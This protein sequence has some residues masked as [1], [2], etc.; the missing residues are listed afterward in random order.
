[1]LVDCSCS[2][3]A[4]AINAAVAMASTATMIG[5]MGRTGHRPGLA[6]RSP[7]IAKI[8]RPTPP[9]VLEQREHRVI[10]PAAIAPLRVSRDAFEVETEPP[11]HAQRR[12]IAGGRRDAH[13]M[14]AE[15]TET[16]VHAEGGCFGHVS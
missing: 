8:L 13:A 3:A 10:E 15:R 16:K 5:A 9:L 7:S 11:D 12:V 2:A 1:S 4:T 14:H 6:R